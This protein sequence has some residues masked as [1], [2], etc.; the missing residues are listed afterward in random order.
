MAG[1]KLS[2]CI[3]N[4]PFWEYAKNIVSKQRYHSN[5]Q[6]KAGV[7][8]AFGTT[9]SALLKISQ[10]TLRRIGLSS[11]SKNEGEL[12]DILDA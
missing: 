11:L 6:V 3:C 7:I 2:L 10:R 5:D 12:T 1:K 8:A 4:K 9:T